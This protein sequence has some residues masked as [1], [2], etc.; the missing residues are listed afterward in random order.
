MIR[1]AKNEAKTKTKSL[2]FESFARRF[3]KMVAR[4]NHSP[5]YASKSARRRQWKYVPEVLIKH[6]PPNQENKDHQMSNE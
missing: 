2:Q 4:L 5:I 1:P 3:G 6:P